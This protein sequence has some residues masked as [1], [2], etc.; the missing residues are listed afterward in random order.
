MSSPQSAVGGF[1]VLPDPLSLPEAGMSL[2]PTARE[3]GRKCEA[4]DE[5]REGE[6]VVRR[7][8]CEWW[9]LS[10][11]LAHWCVYALPSGTRVGLVSF[12][13]WVMRRGCGPS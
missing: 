1:V 13:I 5:R 4:T 7:S 11:S 2:S 9:A 8:V 3:V 12:G 10:R 6:E